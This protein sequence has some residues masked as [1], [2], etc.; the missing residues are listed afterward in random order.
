MKAL[1]VDTSVIVKWY[2]SDREPAFERARTLLQEHTHARCQLH[3]PMLAFYETGNALR[4]GTRLSAAEPLRHLAD[5]F[6][7]G[8]AVHPLTATAAALAHEL[9]CVFDVS[10][11]DACFAALA[12]ELHVPLVTADEKLSH[13]LAALSLVRP[14]ATYRSASA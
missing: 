9:A 4:Y 6:S 2:S 1:V 12:Q 5:L 10:F 7:L 3:V 13:R 11:Y 14:L 8:L